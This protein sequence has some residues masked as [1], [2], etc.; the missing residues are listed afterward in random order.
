MS[1][2]GMT[3]NA[4]DKFIRCDL[5]PSSSFLL[6][7][8]LPS[9]FLSSAL[10]SLTLFWSDSGKSSF[11]VSLF[12]FFFFLFSLFCGRGLSSIPTVS[13]VCTI[14]G[15]YWHRQAQSSGLYWYR[16]P[17]HRPSPLFGSLL[18]SSALIQDGSSVPVVLLL[19][20]AAMVTLSLHT[21]LKLR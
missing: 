6:M 16:Q 9:R 21:Q 18:A 12:F 5:A 8:P 7:N 19:D 14:G 17:S 1:L 15:F 4:N 10:A 20:Q 3:F 2:S 13:P 11:S